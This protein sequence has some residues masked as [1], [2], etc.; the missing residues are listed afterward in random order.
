MYVK[1][2]L[3]RVRQECSPREPND[4]PFASDAVLYDATVTDTSQSTYSKTYPALHFS[5]PLDPRR[6]RPKRVDAIRPVPSNRVSIYS[7]VNFAVS[8]A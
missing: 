5:F 2:P 1:T 7:S 8:R 6:T 3:F 4:D